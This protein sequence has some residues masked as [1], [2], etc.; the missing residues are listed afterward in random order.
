MMIRSEKCR[1]GLIRIID[2]DKE[3]MNTE[4]IEKLNQA[5]ELIEE[6]L[7]EI[8]SRQTYDPETDQLYEALELLQDCENLSA[9]INDTITNRQNVTYDAIT[10]TVK[11]LYR[12]LHIAV[13]DIK[14]SLKQHCDSGKDYEIE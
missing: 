2:M 6:G 1:Q 13:K 4:Q 8:H 7:N 9:Y 11:C 14:D 3:G 5:K 10:G 12:L